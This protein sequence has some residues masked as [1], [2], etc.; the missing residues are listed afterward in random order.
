MA[1]SPVPLNPSGLPSPSLQL[2]VCL[3][4]SSCS[5]SPSL[6][7]SL[8]LS[9]SCPPSSSPPPAPPP[10]SLAELVDCG[11]YTQYCQSSALISREHRLTPDSW[12]PWTLAG[13]RIWSSMRCRESL[14]PGQRQRQTG[15]PPGHCP[16]PWPACSEPETPRCLQLAATHQRPEDVDGEQGNGECD[17]PHSLE[18]AVEPEV[19]LGPAQ[20]QPARDGS[21]RRDEQEAYHVT[22]Q[23]PLLCPRPRVLQPL[24]GWGRSC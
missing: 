3:S 12:L 6:L 13:L 5:F 1:A 11:A 17:E 19:V 16:N 23:R 9:P 21:Q 7:V 8:F 15:R 4:L 18:P 10:A 22:A 2:P 24:R 20:A 14:P